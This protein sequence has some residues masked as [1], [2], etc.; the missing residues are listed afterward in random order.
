VADDR[1][2]RP[3]SIRIADGGGQSA[4]ELVFVAGS[5]VTF[6]TELVDGRLE[7]TVDAAG[8]SA[9][10]ADITGTPTT[11][12]GYGITDACSDAELAAHVAAGDPHTQYALESALGTAAALASDTDGTL[13]ANSDAKLATQKATKT[14]ADAGYRPG[15]TDVAVADGG[16]GSST[17]A[18]ARTNLGLGSAAVLDA[19]TTRAA[20]G[21]LQL[22]A[23]GLMGLDAL[24][25][26]ERWNVARCVMGNNAQYQFGMG[27]V[28]LVGA[29]KTP[30]TKAY[31]SR[32][33]I[34]NSGF[35]QATRIV[36]TAIGFAVAIAF[37]VP[38]TTASRRIWCGLISTTQGD[39]DTA[40]GHFVGI[41]YSTVA[42]DAGWTVVSRDG[43]TQTVGAVGSAPAADV[44]YLL[45][46]VKLPGASSV[47][48]VLSR[49]DTSV[50]VLT[51]TVSANLP[52]AGTAI[53]FGLWSWGQ[54]VLS[55]I[56]ISHA[57]RAIQVS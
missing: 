9:A 1:V 42:G 27:G 41:R 44:P 30:T 21:L 19:A 29:S 57:T 49:L 47:S 26:G 14:Y 48:L 32:E 31:S 11:L 33:H 16:T 10:W 40:S 2:V 17:A 34:A 12:A 45:T 18:G 37:K 5:G 51:A 39:S 46:L 56:E 8:G 54:G 53:D 43:T 3:T 35:F 25:A 20:S 22:D 15:G 36:D 28:T 55:A 7:L 23:I 6:T 50:A 38:V 52:L 4:R 13:A 24:L